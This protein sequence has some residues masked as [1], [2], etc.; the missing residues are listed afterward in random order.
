MRYSVE[1]IR[2]AQARWNL[3]LV[4]LQEEER[5]V[6]STVECCSRTGAT[7]PREAFERLKAT[8][9]QCNEAFQTL[10]AAMERG[11]ARHS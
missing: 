4:I 2:A 7:V 8:R 3:H 10:V 5:R 6:V 11:A 9:A 1:P